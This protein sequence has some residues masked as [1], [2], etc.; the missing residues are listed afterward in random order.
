[1]RAGVAK[2]NRPLIATCSEWQLDPCCPQSSVHD[3]GDR[4]QCGNEDLKRAFSTCTQSYTLFVTYPRNFT[5]SLP[6][7]NCMYCTF[8]VFFS[9]FM[10]SP[11][12]QFSKRNVH[13]FTWNLFC[14]FFLQNKHQFINRPILVREMR[15]FV[16]G[17]K[18]DCLYYL[19]IWMIV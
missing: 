4:S 11:L 15:C 9:E 13:F 7:T 19:D 18:K 10:E 16:T 6:I 12:V 2:W 3:G 5:A 8:I 1:M 17:T 14:Y